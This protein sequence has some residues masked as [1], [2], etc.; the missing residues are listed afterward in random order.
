MKSFKQFLNESVRTPG[1]VMG[2]ELYVHKDYAE[3]HPNIPSDELKKA[4]EKLPKDFDYTAVKYNKKSRDFSFIHSHDFDS[5]HEPTVG[6]SIKVH[7]SGEIKVTNPPKDP[8]IWHHKWQWVGDDYKGFDVN[9]SKERSKQWKSVVGVD[10][11]VSSR[12]GRKSYWDNEI[13]PK[14]KA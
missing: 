6:K 2:N 9:S 11:S 7:S 8:L 5:A 10:K 4:K 1:K 3:K 14:I 12:I 13:V